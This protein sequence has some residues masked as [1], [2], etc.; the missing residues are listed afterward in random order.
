MFRCSFFR[1]RPRLTV[2]EWWAYFGSYGDDFFGDDVGAEATG[3]V[4]G[5]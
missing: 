4:G 5:D 2:R 3:S 1:S